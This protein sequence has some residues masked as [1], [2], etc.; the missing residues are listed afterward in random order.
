MNQL[1]NGIR[2]SSFDEIFD[3]LIEKDKENLNDEEQVEKRPSILKKL[4]VPRVLTFLQTCQLPRSLTKQKYR[5]QM[6]KNQKKP[7][8]AF[9]F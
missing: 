1:K 6:F 9:Y 8:Y 7:N 3:T 2:G 5:M 4:F